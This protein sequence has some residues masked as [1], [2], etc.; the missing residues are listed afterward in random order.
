ML[1]FKVILGN[2][3]RVYDVWIRDLLKLLFC[4]V[5]LGCLLEDDIIN[6]ILLIFKYFKS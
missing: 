1:V 4:D 2:G 5:G 6:I 3:E